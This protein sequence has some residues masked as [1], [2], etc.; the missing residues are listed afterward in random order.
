[1]ERR[2]HAS[3]SGTRRKMIIVGKGDEDLPRGIEEIG[4]IILSDHF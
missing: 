1:L 4:Q 2:R 3:F